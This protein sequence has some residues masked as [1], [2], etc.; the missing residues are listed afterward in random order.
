MFKNT[1][2][3]KLTV[4]AIDTAAN[5]PKAGDAANLTCYVSKDDGA[6]TVLGDTTATELDAT[7][8]P[9]L[10]SFDLA[11]AETNADKLLFSGKSSTSGIRVIPLLLYTVPAAFTSFVTPPTPA[12]NASAFWQDTTAG[13]FTVA[14]SVGKSIMNGVAL[15]TGLTVAR[16]S[17]T[18][19]ATT[20]TNAPADSS[21]T[22]TLLGR[23]SGARA[24]LLDNLSNLDAAISSLNNLSALANLYGSPLLEIPDS[25]TTQFAF[26]LVVR[27]NEGKLVN[28][29]ANPTVTAANAAGVDRSAN[30]SA[31]AHP[32][33]GRY[34]FTYGVS[35]AAAEESL[36]IVASGTVSAEARYVEWI[37]AVVN[38][39]SITTLA[40]IK[41]KTDQLTFTVANKLAVD[42]RT[43]VGSGVA[44]AP[45]GTPLTSVFT[46]YDNGNSTEAT[47]FSPGGAPV[48]LDNLDSPVSAVQNTATAIKAKTDAL[49]TSP[50][51]VGSLM[52]L[53]DGAITDAKVAFPAEAIGRPATFLAAVR[54][55]WEWGANKKTRNRTSGVVTLRNAAD[56]A[57]LE[58]RTESTD[59][60]GP[61]TI[62]TITKGV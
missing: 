41:A 9:G 10:Y 37:G 48:V 29:D 27:D 53:A 15:G 38:Y 61:D 17:L 5:T 19:V 16:C 47:I 26:T 42:V 14:G 24:T 11:Q 43:W 46:F 51:A 60:S 55:L 25:A 54:R 34:T 40:S 33:V 56:T 20:L 35:S 4:L 58:S 50:A 45:S 21:G 1:A 28:L 36:R 30:L 7:N 18:D 6:V 12:A 49:P 31:V 13:D 62:D 3:Q 39:D 32:A 59:L 22:T 57:T 2:A 23:L 8:A 52:N 44:L